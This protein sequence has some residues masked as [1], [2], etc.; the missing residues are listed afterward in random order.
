MIDNH[1][2]SLRKECVGSDSKH[3][4]IITKDEENKLWVSGV[5]G[6]ATTSKALLRAVF[7]YNGTNFC[8]R[9]EQEHRNLKLSQFKRYKEPSH[10]YPKIHQKIDMGD[11]LSCVL[12]T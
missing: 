8:L 6:L 10:H 9:G 4:E 5:L 12:T 11:S 7:F 2:K 1:F 3:T